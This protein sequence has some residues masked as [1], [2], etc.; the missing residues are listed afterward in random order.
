MTSSSTE[1]PSGH[2]L[3]EIGLLGWGDPGQEFQHKQFIRE[4]IPGREA[5]G[6][7]SAGAFLEQMCCQASERVGGHISAWS[8]WCRNRG[9]CVL[10]LPPTCG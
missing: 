10:Q 2:R 6:M 4:L 8:C 9:L 5:G 3:P 7:L 1:V